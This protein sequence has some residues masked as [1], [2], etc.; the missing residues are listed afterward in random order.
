M[1]N[2]V[3]EVLERNEGNLGQTE[4]LSF[5]GFDR[6]RRFIFC[7]GFFAGLQRPPAD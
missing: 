3:V 6:R 4:R 7:S 2:A 5:G 1:I